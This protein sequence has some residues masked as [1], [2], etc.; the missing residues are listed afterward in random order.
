MGNGDDDDSLNCI[1]NKQK[2]ESG[3]YKTSLGISSSLVEVHSYHGEITCLI[4]ILVILSVAEGVPTIN[5]T[6]HCPSSS[7]PQRTSL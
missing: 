2:Y 7:V 3:K 5:V 1:I 6:Y 4:A